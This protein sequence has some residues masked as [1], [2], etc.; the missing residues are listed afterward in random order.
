MPLIL[1]AK[2]RIAPFRGPGHAQ[3]RTPE[4]RALPRVAGAPEFPARETRH[5]TTYS[6]C[7]ST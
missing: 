2:P 1:F 7:W 5:G 4:Q 6:L 3:G